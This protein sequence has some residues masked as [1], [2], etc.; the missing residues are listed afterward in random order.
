M[1]WTSGRRDEFQIAEMVHS[2]GRFAV[3]DNIG[4][5]LLKMLVIGRAIG[6]NT[7]SGVGRAESRLRE[8]DPARLEQRERLGQVHR[9]YRWER[10]S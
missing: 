6:G 4:T 8:C 7:C 3:K 5:G 10:I 1:T 9:G 2:L